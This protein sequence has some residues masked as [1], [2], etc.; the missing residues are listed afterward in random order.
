MRTIVDCID[1][2]CSSSLRGS[3]KSDAGRT[4]QSPLRRIGCRRAAALV[5]WC[6]SGSKIPSPPSPPHKIVVDENAMLS[7]VLY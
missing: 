6:G 4:A 7:A 2:L 1:E 3:L 5:V